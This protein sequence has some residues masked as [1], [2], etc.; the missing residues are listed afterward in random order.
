MSESDTTELAVSPELIA[1]S[2]VF[3]GITRQHGKGSRAWTLYPFAYIIII[4]YLIFFWCLH[5]FVIER[6]LMPWL[7]GP[8]YRDLPEA[9]KRTATNHLMNIL[10]KVVALFGFFPFIM[11]V[12]LGHSMRERMPSGHVTYGDIL[13][14]DYMLF[15]TGFVWEL[16]YR[17]R[18]SFVT[19][20][21]HLVAIFISTLAVFMML[22]D[23]HGQEG[24]NYLQI[25]FVYGFFEVFFETGPHVCMLMY[26]RDRGNSKKLKRSF[27]IIAIMSF[28]GTFLEQ[29][30]IFFLYAKHF[31][32]WDWSIKILT[33]I[34]HV[35]F[36]SAQI[37]GGRI[38]LSMSRKMAKEHA[39]NTSL[40][41]GVKES[42]QQ[43]PD[44]SKLTT[45][46]T[47][48]EG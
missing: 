38:F 19:A 27:L 47:I 42:E 13:C 21:H 6:R 25:I 29:F 48:I 17:S 43:E 10:W 44:G 8:R 24:E 2:E 20:L 16:V 30:A 39:A 33:P 15:V 37:H 36:A 22:T 31:K 4:N 32:T 14:L 5:R 3:T 35:C 18:I 26:T 40:E 41:R 45:T 11:T 34:I 23:R 12:V 1:T 46:V 28:T 7:I 9:K